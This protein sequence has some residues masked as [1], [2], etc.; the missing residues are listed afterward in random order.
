MITAL[1]GN[2]EID[3]GQ[4]NIEIDLKEVDQKQGM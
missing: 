1:F 4:E 3:F 2:I